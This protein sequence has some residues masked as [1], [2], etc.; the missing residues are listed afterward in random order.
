VVGGE[1]HVGVVELART[2]ELVDHVL[3]RIV[4]CEQ[5]FVTLPHALH[6]RRLALRGQPPIPSP[7]EPRLV[8]HVGFAVV[9]GLVECGVRVAPAVAWRRAHQLAGD[10]L[11]VPRL[12]VRGEE[13]DREE[14]RRIV[15]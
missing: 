4:H 14:E 8:R 5:R 10:V 3:D 1:D 9:R 12:V 2:P 11:G 7:D 15:A 13:A 6:D